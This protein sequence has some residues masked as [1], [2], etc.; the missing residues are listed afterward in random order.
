[1]N[2]TSTAMDI[3]EIRRYLPHRYP[4]LLIDRITEVEI[5]SH[6]KA[7]KNVTANEPFFQGHFPGKAVMPGVLVIE[8]MAQAAGILG[9]KSGR[10]ELGLPDE[11]EEDGIYFFV[12]IDKARFRRTVVPGDQLHLEI[13]IIRSRRGI[14]SFTAE[15]RVDGTLVCE[16]EIMCTTAGRGGN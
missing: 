8:A 6:I 12:G 4:F 3:E 16:A 1:M 11:P 10:R 13:K 14:W 7:I 5:G 9:V 15:A 2:P